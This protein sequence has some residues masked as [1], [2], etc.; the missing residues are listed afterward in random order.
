LN[1]STSPF[2]WRVFSK[3]G[4]CETIFLAGFELQSSWFVLPE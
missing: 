3:I 2:M 4:S 1:H